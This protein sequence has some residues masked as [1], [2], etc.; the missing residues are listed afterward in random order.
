MFEVT[1]AWKSAYPE[2]HVGVLV[3]RGVSNPTHHPDLESRK[4]ALEEELRAQFSGQ[5]RA[6]IAS[7]PILQAYG[8][9]YRRFKKTYHNS[10]A[11]RVDRAEGK[12][13]SKRGC[14]G[15]SD[16]HGRNGGSAADGG[17]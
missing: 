1:A 6:R 12:V 4:V 10:A 17:T 14:A 15:G 8:E 7:H 13:H 16:V 5:H 2:A 11:T 9:Y 3:M